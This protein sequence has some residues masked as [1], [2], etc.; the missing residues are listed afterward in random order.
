MKDEATGLHTPCAAFSSADEL[1]FEFGLIDLEARQFVCLGRRAVS[2]FDAVA[3]HTLADCPALCITTTAALIVL[4]PAAADED[5]ADAEP[6]AA[7]VLKYRLGRQPTL[8]CTFDGG[9]DD[10]DETFSLLRLPGESS[11]SASL[12]A[13]SLRATSSE[14]AAIAALAARAPFLASLG[15]SVVCAATQ[16]TVVSAS[17]DSAA[18]AL[19]ALR[20]W[21]GTHDGMVHCCGLRGE[22]SAISSLNLPDGHVPLAAQPM[23]LQH[24]SDSAV[25][26]ILCAAPPAASRQLLLLNSL[27]EPQRTVNDVDS[28]LCHDLLGCGYPQILARRAAFRFDGD[29]TPRGY[30]LIGLSATFAD[31]AAEASAPPPPPTIAAQKAHDGAVARRNFSSSTSARALV[32]N[33]G[34]SSVK[35]GLYD[36]NKVTREA[37]ELC[38]GLTE[39]IGE[40]AEATIRHRAA[41]TT[42]SPAYT[43]GIREGQL[44]AAASPQ[45]TRRSWRTGLSIFSKRAAIR[46]TTSAGFPMYVKVPRPYSAALDMKWPFGVD[47][48]PTV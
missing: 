47:P 40:P 46:G 22:A 31:V 44:S 38:A 30:T 25:I 17:S 28:F 35:Y 32:L 42:G 10:D 2:D 18:P 5:D 13:C 12:A 24:G 8:L 4:R 27:G 43:S 11:T 48:I 26:G 39:R 45:S 6:P 29:N 3:E 1:S 33:A 21:V 41:T 9:D 16:W 19:L 14:D 20:L 34:S 7:D 36:V 15:G 23:P 37:T